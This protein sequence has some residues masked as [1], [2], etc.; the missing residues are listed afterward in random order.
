MAKEYVKNFHGKILGSYE[1]VNNGDIIVRDFYGKILGK[2]DKRFDVTR[3][4][5]GKVIAKGN[6]VG[7]L[8][9]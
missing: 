8:I 6:A 1:T 9:K 3:E 5:Y 7:M 2:Y 4:F